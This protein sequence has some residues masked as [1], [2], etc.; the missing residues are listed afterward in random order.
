MPDVLIDSRA[1]CNVMAQQTWG[2]L[3]LKGI[4]CKSRKAAKELFAYGGTEPLLILG[5]FTADVMLAGINV[6]CRADF[7]EV[8]GN[9]RTLLGRETAEILS[10]LRVGPSQANNVTSRQLESDIRDRHKDLFTGIG[11]LRD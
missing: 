6:R 4:K 3:K 1:T 9:G 11:L 10:R 5:T 8:K 2:L 7:V